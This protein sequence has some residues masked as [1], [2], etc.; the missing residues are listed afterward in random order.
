MSKCFA[1]LEDVLECGDGIGTNIW[2]T[3]G[4][5]HDLEPAGVDNAIYDRL[6][7][8]KTSV[9]I[10]S[11]ALK[12]SKQGATVSDTAASEVRDQEN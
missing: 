7:R 5:E 4:E 10:L 6:G 11:K 1:R 9:E 12:G 3:M 2:T 8:L